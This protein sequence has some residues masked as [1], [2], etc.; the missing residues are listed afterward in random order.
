MK[1]KSI[2]ELLVKLETSHE[3]GLTNSQLMLTNDDLKPG[4][5]SLLFPVFLA[6]WF[7]TLCLEA[8]VLRT[9]VGYDNRTDEDYQ[10]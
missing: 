1:T 7:P 8:R 5:G 9:G 3:P 10:L 6:F 4:K 2:T